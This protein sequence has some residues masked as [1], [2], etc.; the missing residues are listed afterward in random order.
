MT[1]NNQNGRRRGRVIRR[2]PP[3]RGVMYG[4]RSQS[5]TKQENSFSYQLEVAKKRSRDVNIPLAV[6]AMLVAEAERTGASNIGDLYVDDGISGSELSRPGLDKLIADLKADRT[7]SHVFVH[8]RDR[9]ARPHRTSDGGRLE[10]EILDL[11]VTLVFENEIVEPKRPGEDDTA[12]VVTRD[13]EYSR[14]G[15]Y[16]YELSDRVLKTAKVIAEQ[17][18]RL[19]GPA[20]Y[21]FVRILVDANGKEIEELPPLKKVDQPGCHVKIKPKEWD[22]IRVWLWM[23]ELAEKGLGVRAIANRLTEKGIP[24]PAAGTKR[25]RKGVEVPVSTAWHAETVKQLLQ[26]PAI[27]GLQAYGRQSGGTHKRWSLD[28]PRDIDDRDVCVDADGYEQLRLIYNEPGEYVT[29]PAG[30]EPLVDPERWHRLQE[31]LAN[32][33]NPQKRRPRSRSLNTYPLGTRV[34]CLDEGCGELMH[35]HKL[36]GE[37]KFVCSRYEDSDGRECEHNTISSERLF[38][39]ACRM[40]THGLAFQ[41]GE[42]A[43]REK[44]RDHALRLRSA[45]P[46]SL[47][48]E[49]ADYWEAKVAALTAEAETAGR[50]MAVERDDAAYEILKRENSR[51]TAEALKAKAELA[52]ATTALSGGDELSVD[53]EVEA[54][55]RIARHLAAALADPANRE[56]A[57]DIFRRLG[58]KIGLTFGEQKFGP[59]RMVRRLK[60]GVV[61]YGDADFP[62]AARSTPDTAENT[63]TGAPATNPFARALLAA[64]D[65]N[66][67]KEARKS[68]DRRQAVDTTSTAPSGKPGGKTVGGLTKEKSFGRA[69]SSGRT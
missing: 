16:S 49:Q 11:G 8:K 43:L 3:G 30:Y 48:K 61:V 23:I 4:R 29:A 1:R 62:A 47:R 64:V 12:E 67:R 2:R 65:P 24:T 41:A 63:L 32:S 13:I 38:E 34:H 10:D 54:A 33:N 6:D 5:K 17:G 39:F 51:L 28:G 19:G 40:V 20:P 66:A 14:S 44:L 59:K 42:D 37:F 60:G 57:C 58:I 56:E 15:R 18:Y 35:G 52:K 45:T 46:D 25:K 7:I 22:K 69:N 26:N 68:L 50:R 36:H 31:M 53:D 55:V 21:G 9:L 27:I